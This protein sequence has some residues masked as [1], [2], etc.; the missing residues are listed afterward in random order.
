MYRNL[1]KK[2]YI[3]CNCRI[4]VGKAQNILLN[5]KMVINHECFLKNVHSNIS[6]FFKWHQLTFYWSNKVNELESKVFWWYLNLPGCLGN[7][8]WYALMEAQ[9]L[10]IL[11]KWFPWREQRRI[12]FPEVT[13]DQELKNKTK[14]IVKNVLTSPSPWLYRPYL[15]K[16][17]KPTLR[18]YS[19]IYLVSFM[20]VKRV[21]TQRNVSHHA[22]KRCL[23][24]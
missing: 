24:T 17:R 23:T 18:T 9:K 8:R 1:P 15:K 2:E 3:I 6:S 7:F 21:V 4:S 13:T 12:S 19:A 22:T 11:R 5:T 20:A 10:H 16:K 14:R